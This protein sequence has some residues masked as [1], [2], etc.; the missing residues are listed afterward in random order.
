M[1]KYILIF[2]SMLFFLCNSNT[3]KKSSEV[4]PNHTDYAVNDFAHLISED[5]EMKINNLCKNI[6]KEDSVAIVVCTIDSIPKVKKEYEN[7]MIYATDLFNY[8]GIGKKDKDNG[9]LIL[10]SIKDFKVTICTGYF[11]EHVLHDSTCGRILDI[12]M[13]PFF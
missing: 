9:L 1:K 10:L 4:F 8:W 6:L 5:Y 13:I 12:Y 3:D 7:I 2:I 11:T